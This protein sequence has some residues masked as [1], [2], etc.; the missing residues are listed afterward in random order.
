MFYSVTHA[1]A[2][3]YPGVLFRGVQQIKLRTEDR[4]NGDLGAAAP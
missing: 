1:Q 3:M 2:V 4:E